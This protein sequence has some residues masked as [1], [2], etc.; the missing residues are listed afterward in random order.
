[1]LTCPYDGF[2]NS[3]IAL[4]CAKCQRGL[5]VWP[6]W[7]RG[8]RRLAFVWVIRLALVG[9]GVS[10]AWY[11]AVWPTIA[12]NYVLVFFSLSVFLRQ[13]PRLAARLA[14]LGGLAYLAIGV[15]ELYPWMPLPAAT[16]YPLLVGTALFGA[17]VVYSLFLRHGPLARRITL[18][19]IGAAVAL[20]SVSA[21]TALE[22]AHDLAQAALAATVLAGGLLVGNAF[23]GAALFALAFHIEVEPVVWT[24]RDRPAPERVPDLGSPHDYS[25]LPLLGPTV[26]GIESALFAILEF[27]LLVFFAGERYVVKSLN[28]IGAA[29][30]QWISEIFTALRLITAK[31]VVFVA[32]LWRSLIRLV[33][34]AALYVRHLLAWP[35]AS[36]VIVFGLSFGAVFLARD[37]TAYVW[38]GEGRYIVP[39]MLEVVWAFIGGLWLLATVAR[40][41]VGTA[42]KAAQGLANPAF[43][44]VVFWCVLALTLPLFPGPPYHYGPFSLGISLAVVL[45]VVWAFGRSILR[46]RRLRATGASLPNRS[47]GAGSSAGSVSHLPGRPASTRWAFLMAALLVITAIATLYPPEAYARSFGDAVG[48]LNSL[49]AGVFPAPG[50]TPRA[51]PTAIT[52]T[53]PSP[54]P[55]PTRMP[56]APPE[57]PVPTLSSEALRMLGVATDVTN[58]AENDP[59][60]R[61]G[62][63]AGVACDYE[64]SDGVWMFSYSDTQGLADAFALEAAAH[65]LTGRTGG[66]PATTNPMWGGWLFQ[67]ENIN[68]GDFI[69]YSESGAVWIDW[70]Y[71]AARMELI[72]RLDSGDQGALWQA[73]T[74]FGYNRP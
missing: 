7:L 71:E 40:L 20:L 21:G 45:F 13:R 52:G 25:W 42:I 70:T 35:V 54:S 44:A 22:G 1:M 60:M 65:G 43:F 56:T 16:F 50:P 27:I 39:L 19:L 10:I 58:C 23:V 72:M 26:A 2:S 48:S 9:V 29:A 30:Y 74:T 6:G 31:A 15:E 4:I 62:S 11:H 49:L 64:S 73:W 28:K 53:T 68:Q 33:R 12:F 5:V 34:R 32:R 59:N 38:S 63:L 69:I 18:F 37:A 67:N 41:P 24:W 8:R 51:S 36:I 57:T 17:H 14:V 55:T 47:S 61:P 46:D 3:S 66:D